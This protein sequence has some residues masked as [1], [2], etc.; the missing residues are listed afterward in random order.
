MKAKPRE[1]K[2]FTLHLCS[3]SFF[4]SGTKPLKWKTLSGKLG[5]IPSD[6]YGLLPDEMSGGKAAMCDH[7]EQ[8]AEQNPQPLTA[9]LSSKT[10]WLLLLD[11]LHYKNKLSA[12]LSHC[13]SDLLLLL[14][15][16]IPSWYVFNKLNK[17][18][19]V[20]D[21]YIRKMFSRTTVL[22]FTTRNSDWC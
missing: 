20:N 6:T 5:P 17:S 13:F 7:E 19:V 8:N 22:L 12:Y 18:W 10:T 15:K 14:D 1:E 3:S 16:H 9:S 4:L 2:I 11:S 21:I